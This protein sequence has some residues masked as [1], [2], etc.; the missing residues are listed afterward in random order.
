MKDTVLSFNQQQIDK[1]FPFYL[2]LSE[3]LIICGHGTNLQ[4]LCHTT[5]GRHIS[6]YFTFIGMPPHDITFEKMVFREDQRLELIIN[7][8][9]PIRLVGHFEYLEAS[10]QLL[11]IGTPSILLT[12]SANEPTNKRSAGIVDDDDRKSNNILMK[13][14]APGNFFISP[15]NTPKLHDENSNSILITDT[16]G[17]IDWI[18]NSFE[19]AIG[20]TLKEVIGKRPR[21]VL[22]GKDSIHVPI[23]YVDEMIKRRQPFSFE[24]VGYSRTQQ[25]FWFRATVIPIVDQHNEITGR[26]S[27][28]EDITEVK[29]REKALVNSNEILRSALEGAGHGVWSFDYVKEEFQF[30]KQFKQLIGYDEHERFD[31]EDWRNAVHPEDLDQFY[32]DILPNISPTYPKF[33]HEHRLLCKDGQ[34]RYFITRANITDWDEHN[35]PLYSVGTL[36]DINDSKLRS[37][38]LRSTGE[39]LSSLIKNLNSGVLLEDE[40][41]KIVILNEQFCSL[42]SIPMLPEDMIGVDCSESLEQSKYL[43]KD[44]E[45]FVSATQEILNKRVKVID[46]KIEMADGRILQ[47]DYIPIFSGNEYLGHLWKYNDI[48]ES[49]GYHNKL[50]AQREYY[51]NILDQIPADIVIFTYEHKYEFINKTAVKNDELRNWLLGK[52]DYDYCDRKQISRAFADERRKIFDQAINSKKPQ[53]TIEEFT[54]ADGS[55]HF[56]VRVM[57]PYINEQQ[58]IGFVIGYGLDITEQIKNERRLEVEEKRIRTLLEIIH[59]GVIRCEEDG[60][61]NVYNNSFLRIME[62]SAP[63]SDEKLNFFDLLPRES[64]EKLRTGSQLVKSNGTVQTGVFNYTGKSG[65][66]KHIDYTI[67]GVFREEGAAFVVRISDIT[68]A[69]N[70]EKNL[71]NIIEKEKELNTSKSRFIHITSH[72]LRTPLAIIQANTEILEMIIQNG[73]AATQNLKPEK[74]LDR[75]SKEVI[76]MTDILNQLMMISKIETGNVEMSMEK[77]DV[78]AFVEGL[79]EDLYNPYTDGRVLTLEQDPAL[80][81]LHFDKK[82]LRL[83]IVNIVNNAFKYSSGKLPPVLRVKA[84]GDTA[85]FEVEDHG[86][87]IPIDDQNKLFSSF[88]RASN[89][90]VIQGTGLGLNVV[91]YAVKKHAG[92]VTYKSEANIGTTFTIAIPKQ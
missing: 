3:D 42:F 56:V 14:N 23:D 68:D 83:A 53:K 54:A 4:K 1:L 86:I 77:N 2:I 41:R 44:P 67:T 71:T 21:Q 50:L 73:S 8:N 38:E 92:T 60:A 7:N 6:D 64:K 33:T 27:V 11:F 19:R 37:L 47:R 12:G 18:N 59:D 34:Y 43:F 22:Y 51:H 87:G 58:N 55:T 74:M 80:T 62:I 88:F 36:T 91:D 25:P 40:N 30:S 90:G 39:R 9:N 48:T 72:E 31:T 63:E 17:N 45:H 69:V 84:V 29:K 75:I 52:N 78:K 85:V 66:E 79:K 15:G 49:V 20:Y 32:K 61:I 28:L 70:K 46:E 16:S 81:T 26:L 65:E 13:Q 24:N 5:I 89:V 82:L 57:H 10:K 35:M 76:I